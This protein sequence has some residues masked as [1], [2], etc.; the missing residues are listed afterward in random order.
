MKRRG[1][2]PVL[3]SPVAYLVYSAA[4]PDDIQWIEDAAS[5]LRAVLV[6]DTLLKGRAFGGIRVGR[7]GNDLEALADAKALARAMTLKCAFAG[8]DG[9]GA[10]TVVFGWQDRA[11][12]MCALGSY[13][14][15]LGGTYLCGSDLG[16]AAE[17]VEAVKSRTRHIACADVADTSGRTVVECLLAVDTPKS[18][19]VQG[20]GAIGMS[21]VKRLRARGIAIIAADP[22]PQPGEQARA[23]GCELVFPDSIYEQPVDAFIPCAMGNVLRDRSVAQLRAR[24]VCGGANNPL[25]EDGVAQLMAERGITYVPDF[26]ANAGALIEGS[27]RMLGADPE[28]ILSALPGRAKALVERARAEKRSPLD[29]AVAIAEERIASLRAAS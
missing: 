17:D 5:G 12:A 22:R 19:A 27:C 23:L 9:G 6:I 15:K 11:A 13:I 7:Y 18:A 14:D 3:L 26:V 4:M 8:I 29:V 16:F 24:T 25:A 1:Q 28:P 21:V 20:L 10:K 2:N